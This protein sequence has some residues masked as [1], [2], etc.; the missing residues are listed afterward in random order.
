MNFFN[1]WVFV[2]PDNE[3]WHYDKRHLFSMGG[4]DRLFSSREIKIVIFSFRGV[5]ISPLSVTICVFLYGA[6][7][8]NDCDLDYLCCKLA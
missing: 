1:R 4:E 3:A 2:S 5:R 8:V 7:T 6:G